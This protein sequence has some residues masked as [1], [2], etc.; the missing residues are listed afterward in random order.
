MK[1]KGS[2]HRVK[3][4]YAAMASGTPV[5]SSDVIARAKALGYTESDVRLAPEGSYHGLGCGNPIPIAGLKAGETV[6][7]LGCGGGFDAFLAAR[8]VGETGTVIGLDMTPEM[9]EKAKLNASKAGFTNVEFRLADVEKLPLPDCSADAVISNCVVN[10][11]CKDKLAAFAEAFR[12][13]RPGGRIAIADLVPGGPISPEMISRLDEA[14]REWFAASPLTKDGYLAA[15]SNAGFTGIE[16]AK[17]TC[18]S[19]PGMNCESGGRIISILVRATKP[20]S[21]KA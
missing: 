19:H 2:K 17:E 6:V 7:D 1:N 15:I 10:H 18:F 21:A 20:K 9:I 5:P 12:V 16:I 11:A 3:R 8:D 4:M 13:L 14:W